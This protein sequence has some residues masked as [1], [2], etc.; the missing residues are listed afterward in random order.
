MRQ[1]PETKVSEFRSAAVKRPMWPIRAADIPA[2]LSEGPEPE[3]Y[4]PSRPRWP[5][6]LTVS[7]LTLLRAER[8]R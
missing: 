7:V 6:A 1:Q 8:R 4:R 2:L 3:P 5:E